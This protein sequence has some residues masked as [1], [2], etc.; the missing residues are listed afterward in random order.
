MFAP[1]TKRIRARKVTK[2]MSRHHDFLEYKNRRRRVPFTL[3][4]SATV[5]RQSSILTTAA[6]TEM[7]KQTGAIST[8]S[9]ADGKITKRER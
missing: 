4:I 6:I 7:I 5:I 8:T 1:S 3:C 2:V 9:S